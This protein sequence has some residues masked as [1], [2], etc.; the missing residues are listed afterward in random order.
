MITA[1]YISVVIFAGSLS[2]IQDGSIVKDNDTENYCILP[3]ELNAIDTV[4][5]DC[6]LLYYKLLADF[7]YVLEGKND[8]YSLVNRTN[9]PGAIVSC[10]TCFPLQIDEYYATG[11]RV[12]GIYRTF[13]D[14]YYTLL[15]Y[16]DKYSYKTFEKFIYMYAPPNSNDTEKYLANITYKISRTRYDTVNSLKLQED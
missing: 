12:F 11:N 16:I 4:G 15:Q 2:G 6:S 3:E 1:I 5:F 9:N 10:Y 14:G 13:S 8:T 7:I